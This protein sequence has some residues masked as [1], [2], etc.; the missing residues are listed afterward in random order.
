MTDMSNDILGMLIIGVAA[1]ALAWA[2]RHSFRKSGRVLPGWFMPAMIGGAMFLYTVW[3]E[4]TWYGRVTSQ[5]PESV[6]VLGTG[7][8]GKAWR[9]W[10]FVIPMVTRFSAL[11][12]ADLRPGPEGSVE[13]P[14][15]LVERWQPTRMVMTRFDCGAGRMAGVAASG[16]VTQWS[17]PTPDD[18]AVKAACGG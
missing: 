1:A 15:L 9:P 17:D 10:T 16:A 6:V 2:L 12:R 5:L 13:A 4:Y 14:V 7:Q 8:G 18:P 3:N 11:N